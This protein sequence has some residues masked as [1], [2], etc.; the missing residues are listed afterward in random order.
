MGLR[1]ILDLGL[2]LKPDVLQLDL[3]LSQHRR[4]QVYLLILY[5]D[6]LVGL[7]VGSSAGGVPVEAASGVT[8][9]ALVTSWCLV[10]ALS[11]HELL[12][13]F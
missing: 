1:H 10:G 5:H 4:Q 6:H 3:L 2:Q 7:I 13:L 9:G 8:E 11:L 12:L